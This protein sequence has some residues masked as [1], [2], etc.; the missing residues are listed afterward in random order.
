MLI[1]D[2][3]IEIYP[4]KKARGFIGKKAL[5]QNLFFPVALP[6]LCHKSN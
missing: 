5:K 2:I 4:S 1:R 6:L 3:E